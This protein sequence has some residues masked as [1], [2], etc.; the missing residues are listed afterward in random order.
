MDRILKIVYDNRYLLNDKEEM[1][2]NG[3]HPSVISY[4]QKFE[5]TNRDLN[6]IIQEVASVNET[7]DWSCFFRHANFLGYSNRYF[8]KDT[9]IKIN[10]YDGSNYIII[11]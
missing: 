11:R 4:I 1:V 2:L 5:G 3:V 10:G 8:T 9:I 7:Q 6:S